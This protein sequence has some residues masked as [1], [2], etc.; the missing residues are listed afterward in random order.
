MKTLWQVLVV[1]LVLSILS[2]CETKAPEPPKDQKA[3]GEYPLK[4]CVVSGKEL[5]AMGE[6][7]IHKY[8]DKD[9]EREVRFCCKDCLKD[10]EADP[11][12]FL[13]KL[14]EAAKK[15]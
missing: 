11:A 13:A 2:A 10:F 14:D 7:Y 8:K 5:G 1:V 15:K 6:P 4:T 9:Q 3:A 12:K